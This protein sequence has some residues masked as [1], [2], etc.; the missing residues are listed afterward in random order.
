CLQSIQDYASPVQVQTIL[1]DNN[2]SDGSREMV[3]E[4]FPWVELMNSGGNLGFGRANN[5]A[6]Q[7]VAAPFVLYLNPDTELRPGALTAMLD[8]LRARPDVGGVGLRLTDATGQTQALGLQ[9]FP[10]PFREFLRLAVYTESLGRR[11]PSLF[12]WMSAEHSGYVVKIYGACLLVRREVLDRVG[13]FDDRYFM[14]CEDVDLCRRI[15]EGGWRL[16]YLAEP[17]IIHHGAGAS[18]KAPGAFAI[19]MTCQSISKYM[20]KYYGL[21]GDLLHRLLVLLAALIRLGVASLLWCKRRIQRGF[22]PDTASPG[23]RYRIMLEWALGLKHAQIATDRAPVKPV[24]VPVN[25]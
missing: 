1:V 10:N 25:S 4:R 20:R 18:A 17:A 14:Y 3:T 2:S 9:V 6:L 15:I 8:C 12:R 13:A 11:W 19:L 21:P 7:R 16:Y 5:L 24:A 23:K 22:A